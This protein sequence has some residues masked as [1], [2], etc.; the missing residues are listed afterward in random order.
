MADLSLEQRCPGCRRAAFDG[1]RLVR[2]DRCDSL[3]HEQCWQRK[4]ACV[5]A[6]GC[7]GRATPVAVVRT[8]A[9]GPDASEIAEAAGA[10]LEH[11]LQGSILPK[12][13][14]IGSA[15]DRIDA[16]HAELRKTAERLSR[17]AATADERMDAALE[18]TNEVVSDLIAP[19][20]KAVDRLGQRMNVVEKA[21]K[22]PE[23]AN[24]VK[25]LHA[26]LDKAL[27]ESESRVAESLSALQE[28]GRFDAEQTLAAVEACRFD[29]VAQRRPFSWETDTSSAA[30]TSP[31]R[32]S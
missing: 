19:L 22:N 9:P 21:A 16:E 3:Q 23:L 10:A 7:K 1:H 5:A 6:A 12:L 4:K 27:S 2:C 11:V 15:L 28:R 17:R 8:P 30:E 29:V 24:A 26:V 25:E 31:Q 20:R 18:R 13:G 14:T 32:G